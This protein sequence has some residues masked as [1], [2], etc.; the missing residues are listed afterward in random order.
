MHD[1]S[2][3]LGVDKILLLLFYGSEQELYLLL[4]EGSH[5]GGSQWLL[6]LVKDLQLE[7]VI[8]DQ[9]RPELVFFTGGV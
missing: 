1:L 9:L 8:A 5:L 4:D 7:G 6:L 2:Q 3:L